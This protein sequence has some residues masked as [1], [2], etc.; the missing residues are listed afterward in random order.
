PRLRRRPAERAAQPG[1]GAAARRLP[2]SPALSPGEA[3]LG[4]GPVGGEGGRAAPPLLPPHRRRPRRARRPE[5]HLARLRGRGEPRGE[6]LPCLIGGRRSASG[7]SPSG[8]I[9][10]RRA[11]WWTSW[12]RTWSSAARGR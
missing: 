3:G 8:S 12:P 6:D 4:G 2:L 10:T 7:W 9:P 1:G 11:T 5:G